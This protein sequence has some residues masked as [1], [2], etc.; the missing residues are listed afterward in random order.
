MTQFMVI[1]TFL[2][3]CLDRVYARFHDKGRMLPPGLHYRNS[4][5]SKDGTRCFQ[6]MET[7][8]F[9][10]FREWTKN[11]DDLIRFEIVEIGEKPAKGTNS[12]RA[13][14]S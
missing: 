12:Q 5:L 8:Q 3:N 10:L 14:D 4:W 2:E 11:W 13:T 6:L 1:E 7:D 9:E